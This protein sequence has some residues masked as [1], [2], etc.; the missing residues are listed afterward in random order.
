[1]ALDLDHLSQAARVRAY[2]LAGSFGVEAGAQF[3]PELGM[4][5]GT[6]GVHSDCT[7]PS[8]TSTAPAARRRA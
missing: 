3:I 7:R 4:D 6:F 5:Y 1:M 8:T 2:Q